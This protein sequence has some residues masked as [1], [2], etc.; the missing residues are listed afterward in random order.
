[1]SGPTIL[2]ASAL[3][4]HALREPGHEV[5]S[6]ALDPGCAASSLNLSEAVGRMMRAGASWELCLEWM[7]ELP[8]FA[9]PFDREL[10]YQ[11]ARL[12]PVCAPLGLSLADRACLV[13]AARL[14]ADRV[15]TADRAWSK[16]DVPELGVRIQ[17]IR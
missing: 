13:T 16:I 2:D 10:A 11:A 12:A 14:G 15:L 1:M 4:A 7:D 8:V 6:A 9:A 17:V 3:L 5:V